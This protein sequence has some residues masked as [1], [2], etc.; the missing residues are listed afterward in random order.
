[1]AKVRYQVPPLARPL[2]LSIV[3]A[4]QSGARTL[5]QQQVNGGEYVSIDTPYTG[6]ATVTVS[7]G[8]QQVWQERYN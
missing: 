5:R 1:V 7:L 8:E 3:M 4:D 2:N 6:N